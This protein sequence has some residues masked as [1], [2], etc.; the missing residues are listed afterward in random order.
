MKATA[1]L[2]LNAQ[3]AAY[4]AQLIRQTLALTS[5]D[6]RAAARS[7]HTSERTL[8]RKLKSHGIEPDT[9]RTAPVGSPHRSRKAG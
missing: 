5:G 6:V 3:V 2:D 9:Y 1:A 8:W 4:E 7:L